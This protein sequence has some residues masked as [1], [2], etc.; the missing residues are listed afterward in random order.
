MKCVECPNPHYVCSCILHPDYGKRKQLAGYNRIFER[1]VEE[2]S[3]RAY[4][5]M[6]VIKGDGR[7]HDIVKI[8][9]RAIRRCKRETRAT[10]SEIGRYFGKTHSTIIHALRK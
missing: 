3:R 6:E 4:V 7:Q 8:R 10:L 9:D 1:I 2:E 5:P